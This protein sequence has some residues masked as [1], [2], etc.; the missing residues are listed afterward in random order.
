[1]N[2][3]SDN[4]QRLLGFPFR[5][6]DWQG[7]LG[8]AA[9]VALAGWVIPILP[10]MILSGYA[11]QIAR[12]VAL[13]GAEPELP[14]WTD[15]TTFLIDGFKVAIARFLM[16]LPAT[17]LFVVAYAAIFGG[18]VGGGLIGGTGGRDAE[19]LGVL[20]AG[21]SSLTG[22]GLFMI[23]VPLIIVVSL[24]LPAPSMHVALTG[25]I[26]AMFRFKEWWRLIRADIGSWAI[27][28][29]IL[30]GM[31]LIFNIVTAMLSAT[32][33]LCLILPFVFVA[34]MV[35]VTLISEVVFA[36]AYRSASQKL[37]LNPGAGVVSAPQ[38]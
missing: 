11:I 20:I 37:G 16:L 25:Q 29:L 28:Y 13:N 24:L 22:F 35:Y 2:L 17:L 5:G 8:I 14:A 12:Q 19:Q 23:V 34:Y 7:R 3:T 38:P 33:V 15:W 31:G 1:M 18:M 32:V 36:Q 10:W 26:G 21:L 6:P 27:G 4:L 9:L 30:I